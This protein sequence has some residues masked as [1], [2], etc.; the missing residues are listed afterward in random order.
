M[1]HLNLISVCKDIVDLVC[2]FNLELFVVSVCMVCC[3]DMSEQPVVSVYL[4]YIY[5]MMMSYVFDASFGS[6]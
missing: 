2:D 6:E 5:F 4:P 3:R 1:N